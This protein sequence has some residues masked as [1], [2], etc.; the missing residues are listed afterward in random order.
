MQVGRIDRCIDTEV[1]LCETDQLHQATEL[2]P[3]GF[4]AWLKK[5]KSRRQIEDERLLGKIKQFWI[6]NGFAYGYRNITRDMKDDGETGGLNRIQATF[7][8]ASVGFHGWSSTSAEISMSSLALCRV[9]QPFHVSVD[10]GMCP[11]QVA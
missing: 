10:E 11:F 5:P 7:Q 6:E 1:D 3:G 9:S 2:H 4:Y 8:S